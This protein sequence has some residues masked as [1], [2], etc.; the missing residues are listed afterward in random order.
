MGVDGSA[1]AAKSQK[2]R[3]SQVAVRVRA[4]ATEDLAA[5]ATGR[6]VV[7]KESFKLKPAKMGVSVASSS[8]SA[9]AAGKKASKTRILKL[10][11]KKNRDEK[12]IVQ[13]LKKG[14]KVIAKVTVKLADEAGNK[15]RDKLKVKLKR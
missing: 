3:G 2:Q 6:V 10:I 9:K 4:T 12:K 13:A 1:S 14:K 7:G 11:P 8:G 15:D 5:K